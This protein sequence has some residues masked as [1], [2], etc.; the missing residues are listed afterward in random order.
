MLIDAGERSPPWKLDTASF[1]TCQRGIVVVLDG[2]RGEHWDVR[3]QRTQRVQNQQD[4]IAGWDW[5]YHVRSGTKEKSNFTL[6]I[7]EFM[8]FFIM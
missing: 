4:Q 3:R 8:D 7:T 2:P 5:Q 1:V 6:T